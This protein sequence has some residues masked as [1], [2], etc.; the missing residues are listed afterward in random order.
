MFDASKLEPEVKGLQFENVKKIKSV[1]EGDVKD[2]QQRRYEQR[3]PEA[4][5]P[6]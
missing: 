3:Y 4:R 2:R 1:V 6:G 5:Y